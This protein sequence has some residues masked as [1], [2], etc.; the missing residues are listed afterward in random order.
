MDMRRELVESF[1]R[2][3]LGLKPSCGKRPYIVHVL[4]RYS[5]LLESIDIVR[6]TGD[7][8]QCMLCGKV[9]SSKAHMVRHM[10]SKHYYDVYNIVLSVM[11]IYCSMKRGELIKLCMLMCFQS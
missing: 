2:Y 1:I 10:L 3:V 8:Y 6:R 7:G 9:T 11:Q 5:Y 4:G